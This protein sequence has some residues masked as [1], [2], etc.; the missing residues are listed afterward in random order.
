MAGCQARD[1]VYSPV[2]RASPRWPELVRFRKRGIAFGLP[3]PL[4]SIIIRSN[5]MKESYAGLDVE[6]IDYDHDNPRIK[7]ALKKYGEP[8]AEQIAFALR[9]ATENGS[10]SSYT[11]LRGSILAS[12]GIMVP[13]TVIKRHDRYVCIDGNIRLAIYKEFAKT[14]T[15]RAA[16]W[17]RIMAF[18]LDDHEQK[19]AEK[20]RVS[21]HLLGSKEW[22][23]Y[24]K[25]RY[26]HYL[27]SEK[28]MDYGEMIALCGCYKADLE[29]Q[30]DAFHDMNEY[31]RGKAEDTSFCIDRY[32]GFVE[33]QKHG[34]KDAI[35]DA[36]LEM[37]DFG[38]WIR[39]GQILRLTDVRQ[40]PRVL[41]HE[42]AKEVFL[43]G[44]VDSIRDAVKLIDAEER[45]RHPDKRNVDIR[46]ASVH[47]LIAA[48][49]RR[50]PKMAYEDFSDL[51][52]RNSSRYGEQVGA[53]ET[54]S[55]QLQKLIR[56][57]TD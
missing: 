38:N 30:I 10:H 26:L 39:N 40:L 4:D 51:K 33:A 45:D 46:D 35:F 54:L 42:A 55:E 20:I 43:G 32:S 5:T 12:G 27:R 48:L 15:Q 49:T 53:M 11:S 25:A 16:D 19:D 14:D 2:S 23:A 3:R 13:I 6:K 50:I 24:E 17:S 1:A 31:Y 34:I 37:E 28:F 7:M 8:D 41:R 36:G 57:V 52:D 56:D 18:V 21:T 47:Q 9:T 44:G 22:P 29:R